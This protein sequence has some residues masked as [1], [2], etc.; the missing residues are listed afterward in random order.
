M[1]FRTGV[2]TARTDWEKLGFDTMIHARDFEAAKEICALKL[3]ANEDAL[4]PEIVALEAEVDEC[5]SRSV[6]LHSQ[7]YDRAVP[8]RDSAILSLE[9]GM[10][11]S[12]ALLLLALLASVSGHCITFYLLGFDPLLT[13]LMGLGITGIAIAAGHQAFERLFSRHPLVEGAI[14][15]VA[16]ILCFWGLLQVAQTRA[17]MAGRAASLSD[18]QQSFVDGGASDST[19]TQPSTEGTA[20]ES[21][22][23]QSLGSAIIKIMLSA[24]LVL[25]I[26]LG[27]FTR[28]RTNEDFAAWR[29][30]KELIGQAAGAD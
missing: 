26:L 13:V 14:V 28:L 2:K 10:V 16:V 18:N 6:A 9:I 3:H 12:G 5:K 4:R 15:T 23:R 11:I 20:T 21:E 24:D 19:A 8:A 17:M 7:L 25:G 30:L 27:V 29:K 22:V 1:K